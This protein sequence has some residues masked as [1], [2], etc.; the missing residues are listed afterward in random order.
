[1]QA[2][3]CEACITSCRHRRRMLF[4]PFE[5]PKDVKIDDAGLDA[6][7]GELEF[8]DAEILR[9]KAFLEF[10]ESDA[11]L[12]RRVHATL[13]Q[14]A[15]DFIRGFYAHLYA[16]EE[17]RRLLPEAE[18]LLQLQRTQSAYF[19]G[20]TAGDYGRDYFEHRLRVGFVHQ[21][22][23]LAPEWY[24]GAYA[25]YLSGLLPTI[26]EHFG[27]DRDGFIATM[28]AFIKVVLLD[29]G[30]AI[31]AYIQARDK[32]ILGLK[33]YAELVFDSMHDGILVLSPELRIESCNRRFLDLLGEDS[34]V[35]LNRP[36][37]EVLQADDLDAAIR[38]VLRGGTAVRDRIFSL[39]LVRRRTQSRARITLK[40]VCLGDQGDRALMVI[41]E[42]SHEEWLRLQAE[43]RLARN[44]AL[45]RQAQAVARIGSWRIEPEGPDPEAL[46]WSEETYRLF[47]IPAG[48][49]VTY[50]DF[51]ARVHPEDRERVGAAWEA[52]LGGRPY[53]VEHRIEIDGETRWLEERAEFCRDAEG[54]LHWAIGTVQDITERKHTDGRI[55]RLAYYDTL[56][57]LPNRSYFGE[58]LKKK[59]ARARA[60]GHPLALLF[61]DLDRFKDINDTQGHQAGDRVL[62]EVARRFRD[63]MRQDELLARLGGDEFVVI[64]EDTDRQGAETIALRLLA[65]MRKPVGVRSTDFQL[66]ASIGIA[67]YPDDATSAQNLI[68]H[69]DIAMYRAKAGG[70]GHCFYNPDMGERLRRDLELAQRFGQALGNNQLQLHYQPKVL[71]GDGA[72]A[73]AEALLRWQDPEWGWVSPADFLPIIEERGMTVRLGEWVLAEACRQLCAWRD[74]GLPLPPRVAINVSARQIDEK[75]FAAR[76]LAII[77]AA[78]LTPSHFEI[79]LTESSM[80]RDPH[81]AMEV[82]QALVDAG[83]A[84]A[85]D[86]FGTG[87]SSLSYLKRFPVHTLK[88]DRSFVRDMLEDGNDHGIVRTII[89]MA[90]NLGLTPLAEGVEDARQAECLHALGC[91]EAQGFHFGHPLPAVDFAETW[92]RPPCPATAL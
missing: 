92:L 30:L 18:G 49:R 3:Q 87:Y 12:L 61:I 9:R 69:A 60:Q 80:M 50:A 44:E 34:A 42:I 23:G 73:G 57:E 74:A 58:N 66:G 45:L 41:E 81:C 7:A 84:F 21:R 8:G 75:D 11:L 63:T 90:Q 76:A 67:V 31:D 43:E 65:A 24:L 78:G 51:L 53:V 62:A 19:Q 82:T 26:S 59:L 6:K 48:T 83:F 55:E 15:E 54:Q 33:N 79:E 39:Q 91:V 89:A 27:D 1:M 88:I 22:V 52:A 56:T 2:L 72:L 32:T 25:K 20:L 16:F 64:A 4:V 37:A 71:I 68:K 38:A 40:R 17:T 29:M 10:G 28:R 5:E 14:H 36:L 47:G 85:I 77:D 35:P 86:D 70:G 46:E 13:N